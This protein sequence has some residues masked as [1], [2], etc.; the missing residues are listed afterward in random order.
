MIVMHPECV[1]IAYVEDGT[2]NKP[3]GPLIAVIIVRARHALG[4]GVQRW[5][6]RRIRKTSIVA[7]IVRGRQIEPGHKTRSS[8]HQWQGALGPVAPVI[9][10]TD[11][12]RP[13]PLHDRLKGRGKA[14]GLGFTGVEGR[15]AVRNDDKLQ[16]RLLV[17]HISHPARGNR[18]GRTCTA[19]FIQL[20]RYLVRLLVK[21]VLV[22]GFILLRSARCTAVSQRCRV[23][24][25]MNSN[26]PKTPFV[27][28]CV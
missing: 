5:P 3:V 16:I 9:R 2:R 27:A 8:F 22:Y 6:Q 15:N 28:V 25:I 19:W 18:M 26:H 12:D 10:G 24:S 14:A 17:N 4:Q 21:G 1:P 23:E 11:P 20:R 7:R 13:G